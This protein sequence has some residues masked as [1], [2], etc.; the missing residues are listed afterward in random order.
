MPFRSGARVSMKSTARSLSV[1]PA[2]RKDYVTL[3]E[4]HG[5]CLGPAWSA[6]SVSG[7]LDSPGAMAIIAKAEGSNSGV[8]ALFLD[9]AED[10]TAARALNGA[11]G[12]SQVGRRAD[13]YRR[14][15]GDPVPGDHILRIRMT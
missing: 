2:G 12:L 15:G 9:V 14:T 7:L 8:R 4:R 13:C 1:S 10:N 3:A 5:R 6:E 11:A